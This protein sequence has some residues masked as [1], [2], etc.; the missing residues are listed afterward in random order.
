MKSELTGTTLPALEMG[1]EAGGVA[2]TVLRDM[3]GGKQA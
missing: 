2:G 1:L 3:F